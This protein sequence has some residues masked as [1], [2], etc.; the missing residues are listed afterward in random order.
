M[1]RIDNA[2]AAT[3]LP[4]PKPA[5]TGGYFTA[6]NINVGVDATIVEFD[7]LNTLQEELMNIILKGGLASD[8]ANNAQV[9]QAL[10]TMLTGAATIA[11]VTQDILVP[12]WATRIEFTMV[13]SGG[14]GCYCQ[15]DGTNHRTGAGGGSGAYLEAQR[16]VTPGALLHYISGAGGAN[17]A[18]GTS[19]SFAF[20]GQWV[21]SCEG[22]YAG[23]YFDTSHS[24]GG[25]GGNASGGDL[26]CAGNSGENAIGGATQ[27]TVAN[28]GAGPWGGAG[29]SG[30]GN[31]GPGNGPGAGGGGASDTGASNV[32]YN[33]GTG[34][35]GL[36][37][38]RF[39][40]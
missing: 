40:P 34:G 19:S 30:G 9:L 24:D 38:Y 21:A 36:L 33:G 8:K 4:T 17:S 15:S 32:Y 12:P 20:A 5:G 2:S 7:W 18:N 16:P 25:N 3:S 35:P 6:G 13:G 23:Y 26:M 37:K 28:G 10:G 39:L 22:G 11:T 31:G 1:H 27:F 29:V 14:G